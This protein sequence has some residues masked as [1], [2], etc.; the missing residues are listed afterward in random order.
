MVRAARRVCAAHQRLAHTTHRM[1]KGA[2]LK[3]RLTSAL[4]LGGPPSS[5]AMGSGA[6]LA[7]VLDGEAVP[8][9]PMIESVDDPAG[10]PD[11][12]G[13]GCRGRGW[14]AQRG[15]GRS[16]AAGIGVWAHGTRERA[17]AE[18]RHAGGRRLPVRQVGADTGGGGDHVR[19]RTPAPRHTFPPPPLQ[20]STPRVCAR[21]PTP[22]TR[23]SAWPWP[24]NK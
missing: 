7:A 12:E 14:G 16:R 15:A 10:G 19:L 17:R 11:A 4:G 2:A 22:R 8:V 18:G 13:E 20:P 24:R 9:D 3:A 21:R 23:A 1:P 6:R 5:P